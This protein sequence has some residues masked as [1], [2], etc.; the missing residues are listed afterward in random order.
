LFELH[1]GVIQLFGAADN[2]QVPSQRAENIVLTPPGDGVLVLDMKVPNSD[3]LL[4][5]STEPMLADPILGFIAP[6]TNF[7]CHALGLN[8]MPYGRTTV[9]GLPRALV[10]AWLFANDDSPGFSAETYDLTS[11]FLRAPAIPFVA[12]W[13]DGRHE[14]PQRLQD[15]ARSLKEQGTSPKS[16]LKLDEALKPRELHAELQKY[17]SRLGE[18]ISLPN[19]TQVKVADLSALIIYDLLQQGRRK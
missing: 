15:L 6:G 8:V 10:H 4:V 13:S 9:I 1:G 19:G 2:V 16:I 14:P 5:L 7:F 3:T 17:N 18:M 11:G 12:G